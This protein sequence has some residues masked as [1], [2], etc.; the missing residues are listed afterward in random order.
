MYIISDTMV[1]DIWQEI[2]KVEKIVE[3]AED[4]CTMLMEDLDE[5]SDNEPCG[6]VNT[7]DDMKHFLNADIEKKRRQRAQATSGIDT[8]RNKQP[9]ILSSSNM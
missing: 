6:V 3:T 7:A 9:N 8:K 1:F 5:M 2:E 4:M